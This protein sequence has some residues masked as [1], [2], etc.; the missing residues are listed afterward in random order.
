MNE[1]R[2]FQRAAFPE[3][4]DFKQWS[5]PELFSRC[6]NPEAFDLSGA[7]RALPTFTSLRAHSRPS[8]KVGQLPNTL[9]IVSLDI[10]ERSGSAEGVDAPTFL[11]PMRVR[12]RL[13]ERHR[14]RPSAVARRLYL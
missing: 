10:V 1:G 5:A 2:P 11:R 12:A 14:R 9:H 13:C 8:A 4:Y 7:R 3:S 6:T